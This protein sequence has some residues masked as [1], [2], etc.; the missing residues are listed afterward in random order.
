LNAAQ[1]WRAST[2]LAEYA[3]ENNIPLNLKIL[4]TDVHQRSLGAAAEG[5]YPKSSLTGLT[6][7]QIDRYFEKHADY[8]QVRQMLRRLVVFSRHNLLRDPPFTRMD[9]VTCRNVMIYF[10]EQAQQKTLALF[11]FALRTDGFL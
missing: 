11:H 1:H 5:L 2:L 9:L 4:A 3:R 7:E 8:Y 6:E 10:K